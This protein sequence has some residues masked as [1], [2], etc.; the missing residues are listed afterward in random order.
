MN[1]Y[2]IIDQIRAAV[3]ELE[4]RVAGAAD[5]AA[6]LESTINLA[7]P[8]A[9]VVR[10][11]DQASVN[12]S[13]PGVEQRIEESVAVYVQF[14]NTVLSDA[15]RR[16]GFAGA[17]QADAMRALLWR[18]LIN[19]VPPAS[20]DHVGGKGGFISGNARL[21]DFDRARLFWEYQFILETTLTDADGWSP[22]GWPLRLHETATSD[23]SIDIFSE[24]DQPAPDALMRG[25]GTLTV[26]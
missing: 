26:T 18:A 19:W 9:F 1:L 21:I 2:E 17:N 14:D 15:D 24:T 23:S 16:T 8:C 20:A 13:M 10:I 7:M 6:G 5:F 25:K 4:G 11:G 22:S 12:L 3:P